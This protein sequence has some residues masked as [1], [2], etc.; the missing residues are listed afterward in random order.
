MLITHR[1]I[2]VAVLCSS[3]APGLLYLLNQCPDRAVT[4]D[5]VCCVT[6]D[7]TFAEEVRVERRGIPT[8]VHPIHEWCAARQAGLDDRGVRAEYDAQT[9]RLIEPHFPDL[10]L[11]DGYRYQVTAPLLRAFPNRVLNLHYSDLT[12]R[13]DDGSPMFPG[14][15]AVRDAIRAGCHE[16]RTTVHLVTPALDAGPPVVRSGPFAVS[17]L[18]EDL[19]SQPIDDAMRAYI[20]AHQQWMMRTVSGPLVAAAM[21]LIA[22]GFVDLDVLATTPDHESMWRLDRVEGLV[23]EV[24]YAVH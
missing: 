9:L 13:R 7:V 2:R 3:R 19:R 6:S 16:T 15:R 17:P 8:H 10:L 1:P 24:A 5:I 20:Y 4:Y 11:L 21:R 18:V 14:L 22:N 12:L 23:P